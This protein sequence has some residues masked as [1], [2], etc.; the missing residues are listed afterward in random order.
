[1]STSRAG[2]MEHDGDMPWASLMKAF[3]DGQCMRGQGS[4]K[5]RVYN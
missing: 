1:M 2:G 4:M 3:W 5:Y